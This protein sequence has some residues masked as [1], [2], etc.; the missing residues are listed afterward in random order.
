MKS[1]FWQIQIKEEDKY[2]TA[3]TLPLGYYEWDVMP[4]G[5]KNAPLE[6]QNIMNYI[7]NNYTKFSIVYIDDVLIFSNSIEEHFQHL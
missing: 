4:F 3:F 2:K 1:G 6:F 5:L 7:F